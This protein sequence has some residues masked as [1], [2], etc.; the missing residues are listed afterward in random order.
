MHPDVRSTFTG[1]DAT[2]GR[3]LDGGRGFFWGAERKTTRDYR[4]AKKKPSFS[5]ETELEIFL[6]SA[7]SSLPQRRRWKEA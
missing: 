3:G 7:C 5:L 6:N 2:G 1:L 4:K